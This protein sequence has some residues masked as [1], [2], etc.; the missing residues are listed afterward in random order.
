MSCIRLGNLFRFAIATALLVTS[1]L[2][3][4][5]V[6]QVKDELFAGVEKLAAKAKESSEINLDKN[7]LGLA[8]KGSGS[9]S[10]LMQKMEFIVVHSFTFAKEGDYD[11]ADVDAIVA[12]LSTGG[13]SQVVKD[14]SGKEFTEVC[15]KV[16][17]SGQ[18]SELVVISADPKDLTLVHLKGHLTLQELMKAGK[19]YGVPQG[20]MGPLKP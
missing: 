16:D 12:R 13:W 7:L 14:R 6:P 10:A 9:D 1:G 15:V 17:P 8:G 19:N 5:A 20:N 3:L 11:M 18:M 4:A 2:A